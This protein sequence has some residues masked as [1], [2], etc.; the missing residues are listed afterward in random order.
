MKIRVILAE[1][2]LDKKT[3]TIDFDGV[4]HGYT[5]GWQDGEIYDDLVEGTAEA[6]KILSE[7]YDLILQSARITEQGTKG[8]EKYLKEK[9]IDKYFVEVTN[10]KKPSERYIDDKG[11]KFT[12]WETALKELKNDGVIRH[13]KRIFISSRAY[14]LSRRNRR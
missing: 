3:L 4:V 14:G 6:L 1:K 13:A 12:S 5:K 7:Q 2:D 10:E 8:I 11:L 9:G